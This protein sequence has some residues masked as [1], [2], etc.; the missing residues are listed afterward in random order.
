MPRRP[1]IDMVGY[2]HIVN[3]G[4]EQRRVY[5]DKKD[6]TMFLDLLCSG[7]HLYEV[8]LHGYVL[9]SNHYHLLIE[10]KKE[11][12]SKFMKHLNASYAIYFNKKYK[13]AG[14][15]WQGRFKSWYVTDETYLYTLISYIENN[16]VKAKML[17]ALGEYEHSSYLSFI[18]ERE[19]I[20][21]LRGSFVFERFTKQKERVE[22]FECGV[23][24]RILEEI[25]KA[26]NLV[27]TSIKEKKLDKKSLKH[28][29]QQ[30]ENQTDRDKKIFK[31]YEIGY[32]QHA[33]T[34]YLQ[35]SQAQINRVIKKI[36]G[37]GSIGSIDGD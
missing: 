35:L 9:M 30:V 11:N 29:F 17:K 26:S 5:K 28:I 13:R 15:L 32:S 36:R 37:I 21:C 33:I 23:D 6:F 8:Q 24:E 31:A 2:Y 34:K 7:C 14:H 27:V 18:E 19:P 20:E 12:I 22:F 1:R 10:T 3:R 25:Q 4:V 16:P